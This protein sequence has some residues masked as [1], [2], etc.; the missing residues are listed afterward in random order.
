P[1]EKKEFLFNYYTSDL[2]NFLNY[3]F[4][5]R[6]VAGNYKESKVAERMTVCVENNINNFIK[7]LMDYKKLGI[8]LTDEIKIIDS[9]DI[10]AKIKEKRSLIQNEVSDKK[11]STDI[12]KIFSFNLKNFEI[13]HSLSPLLI[14]DKINIKLGKNLIEKSSPGQRVSTI[15]PIIFLASKVPLIIDQPEDNLDNNL[16]KNNIVNILSDL[17]INRQIIIATHNA[18]MVILGDAEQVIVMKAISEKSGEAEVEGFIDDR[19]VSDKAVSLLEGGKQA[20]M[21]RENFYKMNQ[22]IE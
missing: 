10:E 17:K 14:D 22:I 7:L 16:I 19:N 3:T 2:I 12:E 20:F 4:L 11:E 15:L 9:D 1:D 18:N 13:I 6:D 8:D 5:N 21:E